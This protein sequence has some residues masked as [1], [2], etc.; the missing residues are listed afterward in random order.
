MIQFVNKINL[1]IKLFLSYKVYENLILNLVSL[2]PP[3]HFLVLKAY[4]VADIIKRNGKKSP[5]M[6]LVST[7]VI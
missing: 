3:G 2:K 7:P 5:V 4:R 6:K 1:N